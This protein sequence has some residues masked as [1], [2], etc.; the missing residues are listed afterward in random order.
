[1]RN[2]LHIIQVNDLDGDFSAILFV[3]PVAIKPCLN[4]IIAA[5]VKMCPDH[6]EAGD[7]SPFVDI[8]KG[9]PADAFKA[10][11]SVYIYREAF[12]DV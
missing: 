10:L 2:G 3:Q 5:A 12:R 7:G 8:G 6:K 4:P 1:M 11:I 9:A